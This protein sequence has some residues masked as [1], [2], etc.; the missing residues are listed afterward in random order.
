[1]HC[2]C[3]PDMI[4]SSLTSVRSMANWQIILG[5]HIAS[6]AAPRSAHTHTHTPTYT[7]ALIDWGHLLVHVA[8]DSSRLLWFVCVCECMCAY[9]L[10]VCVWEGTSTARCVCVLCRREAGW[11]I[12]P[13]LSPQ[14]ST[15]LIFS[16]SPR[17][18][19]HTLWN[20]ERKETSKE[21]NERDISQV[22]C[23]T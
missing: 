8:P 23:T 19:R 3:S 21:K 18:H 9:M 1:M 5:Y 12:I 11:Q 15:S 2:G 16:S 14:T 7:A 10:S 22:L 17:L 6:I 13:L 4:L 20:K